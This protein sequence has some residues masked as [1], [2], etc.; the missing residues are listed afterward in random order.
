M[1]PALHV[2][3]LPLSSWETSQKDHR[4]PTSQRGGAPCP[5]A[6]PC[7]WGLLVRDRAGCL[8]SGTPGSQGVSEA[9]NSIAETRTRAGSTTGG[10]SCPDLQPLLCCVLPGL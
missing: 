8:D 1:S 3:T 2:D 7:V 4:G 6:L 9:Q 10:P 5:A